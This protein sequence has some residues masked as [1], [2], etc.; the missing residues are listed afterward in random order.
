MLRL[1]DHEFENG[2]SVPRTVLRR[3]HMPL[4]I[5][6]LMYF[7]Y[8]DSGLLA[9]ASS[10]KCLQST[11]AAARKAT[12]S[13]SRSQVTTLI[14]FPKKAKKKAI[15]AKSIRITQQIFFA[16]TKQQLFKTIL[17]GPQCRVGNKYFFEGEYTFAYPP[18]Q[19][20][21]HIGTTIQAGYCWF[22]PI[23]DWDRFESNE[24]VF[25][26][27]QCQLDRQH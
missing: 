1:A 27:L 10:R 16:I 6:E 7:Q 3:S 18:D 8:I 4:N 5:W 2:I 25:R 20:R 22:L 17:G 11:V 24:D 15:R 14:P 21:S 12:S 9:L 23:L 26:H 13:S 19:S